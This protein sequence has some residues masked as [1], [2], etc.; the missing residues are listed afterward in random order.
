MKRERMANKK[1]KENEGNVE[2]INVKWRNDDN[3]IMQKCLM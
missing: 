3:I 2:E 1:K